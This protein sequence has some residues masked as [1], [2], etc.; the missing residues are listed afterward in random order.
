MSSQHIYQYR[1]AEITY[2]IRPAPV[3]S[4]C[5]DDM[6]GGDNFGMSIYTMIVMMSTLKTIMIMVI[7]NVT[8]KVTVAVTVLEDAEEKENQGPDSI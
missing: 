6:S 5:Y 4:M 1:N 3:S 2:E 7:V 8:M